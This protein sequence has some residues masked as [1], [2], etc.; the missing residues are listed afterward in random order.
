MSRKEFFGGRR[1][2]FFYRSDGG[3][4]S[5]CEV[6]GGI[7]MFYTDVRDGIR[8]LLLVTCWMSSPHSVRGIVPELSVMVARFSIGRRKPSLITTFR[9]ESARR[10][11]VPF[12]ASN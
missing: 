11:T 1:E 8:L 9:T 10:V 7:V 12:S 3:G 6:L 2:V 4:G 5:C